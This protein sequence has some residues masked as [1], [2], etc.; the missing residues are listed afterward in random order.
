MSLVLSIT[1][2]EAY[3]K[4]PCF[5]HDLCTEGIYNQRSREERIRENVWILKQSLQLTPTKLINARKTNRRKRWKL[6]KVLAKTN[7]YSVKHVVD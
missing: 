6:L 2:L 4:Q 5:F 3:I 1:F 7:T